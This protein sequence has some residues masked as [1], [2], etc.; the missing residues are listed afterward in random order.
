MLRKVAGLLLASAL[1][2]GAG[3]CRDEGPAE[4]A[5]R[6]LDEAVEDLQHGGEGALERAGRKMDEAA[7]NVKES[8]EEL[9]KTVTEE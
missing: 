5:G 4:E 3:G 1:V 2:V 9:K 8:A 7:E 6:K